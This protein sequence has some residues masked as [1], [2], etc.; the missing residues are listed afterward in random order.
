MHR[1]KWKSDT[2]RGLT[3]H[4]HES[5]SFKQFYDKYVMLRYTAERVTLARE[6]V[7]ECCIDYYRRV[8]TVAIDEVVTHLVEYMEEELDK[9]ESLPKKGSEL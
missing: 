2:A 1:I 9:L 7:R 4:I 8:A 3:L 6:Y 5:F